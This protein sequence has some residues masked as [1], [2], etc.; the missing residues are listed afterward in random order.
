M[1]QRLAGLGFALL[2]QSIEPCIR[3]VHDFLDFFR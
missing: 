2:D 1:S 3:S